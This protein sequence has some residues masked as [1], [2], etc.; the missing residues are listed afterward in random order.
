MNYC[1]CLAPLSSTEQR[2]AGH[3]RIDLQPGR[4]PLTICI[5]EANGAQ[6][7]GNESFFH[8]HLGRRSKYGT[9]KRAGLCSQVSPN[10]CLSSNIDAEHPTITCHPSHRLRPFTTLSPPSRTLNNMHHKYCLVDVNEKSETERT[11]SSTSISDRECLICDSSHSSRKEAIKFAL[12][13]HAALLFLNILVVMGAFIFWKYRDS[14][15]AYS[16]FEYGT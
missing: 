8:R 10:V 5:A 4:K 1:C 15:L 7:I 13:L 6:V 2:H 3:T 12:I 14:S 11:S 16:R 9:T